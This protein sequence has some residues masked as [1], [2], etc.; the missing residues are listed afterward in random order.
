VSDGTAFDINTAG[1]TVGIATKYTASVSKGLR[2]V[3][4]SASGAAATEL[5]VLGTDTTGSTTSYAWAINS[6]DVAAGFADRYDAAGIYRGVRAVRWNAATT[7][8]MEMQTLGASATGNT[9]STAYAINDAGISA[10][11]CSKYVGGVFKG[12]RAVLWDV[13][14]NV[15]ELGNL[16]LSTTGETHARAQDINGIGTPVGRADDYD[17]LGALI[18]K[19]AVYWEPNGLAVDLNTLIDPSNGWLLTDALAISDTNWVAGIG[20]FDPDGLGGQA[21]Y[22][23]AFL[24]QIP[25]T[26]IVGWICAGLLTLRYH[27]RAIPLRFISG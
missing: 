17:D 21:A 10:G 4:W 13:L 6:G 2:A 25:E 5:G 26:S 11:D 23:R 7:V 9:G 27:R 1:T 15:T 18:G 24:V 12:S 14:G 20:T 19:R 16:G 22:Q 3:R 8:A